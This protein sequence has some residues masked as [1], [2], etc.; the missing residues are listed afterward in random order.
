AHLMIDEFQDLS[1]QIV[2]CIPD[3]MREIRRRGPALQVGRTAQHSSL[4]C[5]RE[6]RQTN[7]GRR[8]SSPKYFMEFPKEFSSPATS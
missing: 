1:P 7:Y 8:G 6:D 3:S 2:S 5:V 4:L